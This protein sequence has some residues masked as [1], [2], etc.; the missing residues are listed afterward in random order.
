MAPARRLDYFDYTRAA[1]N[2]GLGPSGRGLPSSGRSPPMVIEICLLSNSRFQRCTMGRPL[3]IVPPLSQGRTGRSHAKRGSPLPI[4]QI[5]GF[6]CTDA[7]TPSG[8]SSE[9]GG[10]DG[11]CCGAPADGR[12]FSSVIIVA[13]D[14]LSSNQQ[15]GPRDGDR[16]DTEEQADQGREQE[17]HDHVVQSD[18][19]EGV[20]CCR[21]KPWSGRSLTVAGLAQGRSAPRR[22]AS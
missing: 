2:L 4:P 8:V 18:L 5:A 15:R 16:R 17:D 19:A 12:D 14:S 11:F 1:A 21:L 13:P 6:Q 22:I 20:S 9:A 10:S 3:R 7:V